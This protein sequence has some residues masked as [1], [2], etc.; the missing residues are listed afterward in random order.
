MR[1]RAEKPLL[2]RALLQDLPSIYME[3]RTNNRVYSPVINHHHRHRDINDNVIDGLRRFQVE[4]R[5]ISP[6]SSQMSA[7]SSPSIA[8]Q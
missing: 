6:G 1:L 3:S 7:R 8:D 5:L 2:L 4:E